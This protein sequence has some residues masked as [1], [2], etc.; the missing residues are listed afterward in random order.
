M[1]E[2]L[3]NAWFGRIVDKKL[4]HNPNIKDEKGRTVAYHLKDNKLPVP[5]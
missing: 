1:T 4:Y 2:A 5:N 3:Y